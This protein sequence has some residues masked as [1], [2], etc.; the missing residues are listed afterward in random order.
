MVYDCLQFPLIL[1]WSNSDT[2]IHLALTFS[3]GTSFLKSIGRFLHKV[4]NEKRPFRY[5][6]IPIMLTLTPWLEQIYLFPHI[7]VISP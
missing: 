4:L 6:S 3:S 7:F 5:A 2:N 1:Y